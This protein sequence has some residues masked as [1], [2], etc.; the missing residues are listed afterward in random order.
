MTAET[1]AQ[2][3]LALEQLD[4][5]ETAARAEILHSHSPP[6]QAG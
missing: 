1:Q 5:I 6:A 4:A 2:C 3:L